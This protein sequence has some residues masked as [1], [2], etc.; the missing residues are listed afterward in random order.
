MQIIYSFQYI[1]LIWIYF[2]ARSKAAYAQDLVCV[3]NPFLFLHKFL[4]GLLNGKYRGHA[5]SIGSVLFDNFGSFIPCACYQNYHFGL[6]P[7]R[8]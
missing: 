2:V 8:I 7:H 5:A 4:P 1:H 3:L 6:K